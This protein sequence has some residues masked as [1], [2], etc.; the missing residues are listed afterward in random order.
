MATGVTG[1]T[2][3]LAQKHVVVV[4]KDLSEAATVLLLN[5]VAILVL[6]KVV[7]QLTATLSLAQLMVTGVSGGRVVSVLL[8][9]IMVSKGLLEN[10]TTHGQSIRDWSAEDRSRTLSNALYNH[11]QAA[12]THQYQKGFCITVMLN[13]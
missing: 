8:G 5:V 3:D 2:R 10:V 11:V 9:V 7:Q 4:L 12:F 6:E 1:E 13:H